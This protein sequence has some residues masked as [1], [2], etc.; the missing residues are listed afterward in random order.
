MC[1]RIFASKIGKRLV[2]EEY[3]G[4]PHDRSPEGHS[5]ALASGKRP[6]LAVEH[7]VQS[8]ALRGLRDGLLDEVLGLF[9][10]LQA[11][12]D[13][14]ENAHVRI[15]RVVLKD[16]RDPAILGMHVVDHA[17]TDGNAFRW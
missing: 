7:F 11:K 16:H 6:R 17:V 1:T 15:E 3:F 8:E 4:I 10:Q 2:K 9:R 5:L 14:V 13:V 12:G